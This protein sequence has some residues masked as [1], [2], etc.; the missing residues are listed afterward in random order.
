MT[1]LLFYNTPRQ[2]GEVKALSILLLLDNTGK[3]QQRRRI[4]VSSSSLLQYLS[5]KMNY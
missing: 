1:M 2:G 4:L 3:A 5:I